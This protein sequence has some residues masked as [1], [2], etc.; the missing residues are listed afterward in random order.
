MGLILRIWLFSLGL[1]NIANAA[2]T[3]Y[4]PD[5]SAVDDT[6]MPCDTDADVS[7]CCHLAFTNNGGDLCGSGPSYGLCGVTGTQLWRES[8]TDPTWKSPACLNLCTTGE[9][10]GVDAEI[11]KCSDGTY[12]C[13]LNN[14]TCCGLNQG[15]SIVNNQVVSLTPSS[16]SSTTSTPTSPSTSSPTSSA[17]SSTSSSTSPSST[18]TSPGETPSGAPESSMPSS[19]EQTTPLNG[20]VVSPPPDGNGGSSSLSTGATVG[21]AVGCTAGGLIALGALL[22]FL[23]RRKQQKREVEQNNLHEV[24]AYQYSIQNRSELKPEYTPAELSTQIE[25]QELPG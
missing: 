17:S 1:S 4:R 11:T 24:A 15:V 3:C 9:Y 21:I 22:F 20:G 23:W 7:M 8:C 5:G 6:Y 10:H 16:T 25:R 2:A 18:S 13:G 19:P 14:A 12:C